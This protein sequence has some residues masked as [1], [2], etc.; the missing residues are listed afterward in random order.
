ML[1]QRAGGSKHG[2][3][4]KKELNNLA[5]GSGGAR[6]DLEGLANPNHLAIWIILQWIIEGITTTGTLQWVH[7]G[8]LS[9][10]AASQKRRFL[11]VLFLL[12]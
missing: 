1:S 8:A 4:T 10:P 3:K 6:L 12:Q 2:I 11:H 5:V 7:R 9:G